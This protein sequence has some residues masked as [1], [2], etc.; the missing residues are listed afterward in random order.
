MSE[1][2]KLTKK[3]NFCKRVLFTGSIYGRE[4]L[5][6]YVDADVYVLPSLYESFSNTVL[7][8]WACGTPVIVTE[9]CAISTAVRDAGIV[10]KRD[11][12]ELAEGIKKIFL[13]DTLS[14]E[15]CRKGKALI[16]NEFDIESVTTKIEDCYFKIIQ[17]DMRN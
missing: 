3:F 13:N 5:S 11:S 15:F 8:A 12:N 6:A 17:N 2:K 7:E 14:N 1:L 4:K 9:S 16:K 10:V